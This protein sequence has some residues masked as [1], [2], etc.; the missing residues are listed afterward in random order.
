MAM[1][2]VAWPTGITQLCLALRTN[3]TQ[4]PASPLRGLRHLS[5]LPHLASL[6]LAVEGRWLTGSLPLAG[7]AKLTSLSLVAVG[8]RGVLPGA[9]LLQGTT[10]LQARCS[11]EKTIPCAA[12]VAPASTLIGS[13]LLIKAP[14]AAGVWTSLLAAAPA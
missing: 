13:V 8:G 1:Q 12:C 9:A 4:G 3:S 11:R 6:G 2:E 14:L 7:L 5:S 10:N